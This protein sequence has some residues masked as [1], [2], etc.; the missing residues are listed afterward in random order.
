MKNNGGKRYLMMSI[1]TR[2]DAGKLGGHIMSALSNI[3][4]L[5]TNNANPLRNYTRIVR[6]IISYEY[7]KN[8]PSI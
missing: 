6:H 2:T 7:L 8:I 5:T 3:H 1:S 4:P